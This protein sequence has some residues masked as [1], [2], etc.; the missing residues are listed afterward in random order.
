VQEFDLTAHANRNDLLEFVGRVSPR[1][2]LLGHGND[3]ARNWFETQIHARWPKIKVFQP[4]PAKL[5]TV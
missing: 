3:V 1:V 5:I 2:V 4:Q